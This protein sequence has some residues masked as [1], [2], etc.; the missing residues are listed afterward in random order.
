[1]FAQAVKTCL[2]CQGCLLLY[3]LHLRIG[4]SA[5]AWWRL[6]AWSHWYLDKELWWF[7]CIVF[8]F[9]LLFF[10]IRTPVSRSLLRNFW[11]C[12]VRSSIFAISLL[13]APN[14]SLLIWM[15]L[16]ASAAALLIWESPMSKPVTT[17]PCWFAPWWMVTGDIAQNQSCRP[18]RT[19]I[20]WLLR[21]GVISTYKVAGHA[22][23][24]Q[25]GDGL[26][27]SV[28]KKKIWPGLFTP[29]FTRC[30]ASHTAYYII[31]L[32]TRDEIFKS[33]WVQR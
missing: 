14:P 4:I 20:Q 7:P 8:A 30:L 5:A 10:S 22:H 17:R 3:Q 32:H 24:T 2:C 27:P 28:L 13:A 6:R 25:G 16:L 12:Y 9:V 33:E 21:T 18:C 15:P 1:M 19:W 31:I 11:I 26:T 29:S 23:A